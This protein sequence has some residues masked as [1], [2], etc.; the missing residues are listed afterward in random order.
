MRLA[1]VDA[2]RDTGQASAEFRRR[3]LAALVEG[4]DLLSDA[5]QQAAIAGLG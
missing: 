2:A 1:E 5:H 4:N 3:I